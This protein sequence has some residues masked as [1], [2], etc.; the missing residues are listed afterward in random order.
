MQNDTKPL[1]TEVAF[2]HYTQSVAFEAGPRGFQQI[3]VTTRF[4]N[5]TAKN[6]VQWFECVVGNHLELAKRHLGATENDT[7]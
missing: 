7:S 1:S 3:H 5:G 4:F 6:S 2:Q